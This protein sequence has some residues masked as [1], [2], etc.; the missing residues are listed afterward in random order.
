[1][2]KSNRI[3]L[4][5]Y[6]TCLLFNSFI[7]IYYIIP[8]E[9]ENEINENHSLPTPRI[10]QN[11]T[12]KWTFMVYL[13][14][15][16]NLETAAIDDIN[17]MEKEGSDSNVN[18][19]VQIDRIPNYDSSNG[20]WSGARRY[21]ITKDYLISTISSPVI[22]DIGEV[23]MG[24]GSTLQDFIVWT[25]S[26]YPA[27]NYALIL[28]DHGTG[29]MRGFFPGGVCVDDS[30]NHDYLTI[31]EIES[32]LST[33][34]VNLLG[35]DAC[36][37]G[38]TEIHYQ[39][40]DYVD[41][42]VAS[43]DI[44]PGDGYP[45]NDILKYLRLNPTCTPNQLGEQ[46]VVKYQN[47]YSNPYYSVTQAAVNAFT[48]QFTSNL[49][50]FIDDLYLALDSQYD[51]IKQAREIALE[52][53]YK[54]YID[55]YDF[56]KE[57]KNH[58]YGPIQDMANNLMGS[59]TEIVFKELH[60][61]SQAGASG[62]SIYFPSSL[63]KYSPNYENT[64]FAQDL[65]WDDFL[66]KY[67]TNSTSLEYDDQFE[68]NDEKSEAAIVTHGTY[69]NLMCN[70]TDADFF[71]ISSILGNKVEIAISFD[72]NEG[73]LD[74][75]LYNITGSLVNFSR[76]E[77]NNENVSY[78]STV[79]EPYTIAIY[80]S[81]PSYP[82]YQSYDLMIDDGSDDYF[83]DNDEWNT[84]WEINN[85]TLYT[86]L[87]C[88]DS[89]FYKLYINEGYFINITINFNYF[90]GDLELYLW[91]DLT[92]PEII[93]GSSTA[94][95][96]ENILKYSDYSGWY[97]IEVNN[98]EDN[99]DYSLSVNVSYID[100]ELEQ[101]EGYFNNRIN[102]ATTIGYGVFDNLTCINEDFYNI[103]L[104][105]D[106]WVNITIFFEN[107]HGDLDL[108][109]IYVDSWSP[110]DYKYVAFSTSYTDNEFIYYKVERGGNYYIYVDDYEIN[111]DYL[112]SVNETI[113][114]WDDE[115]EDNEWFDVASEI[116]IGMSYQNLS[117]I[118]WDAYS[119]NI[120]EGENISISLEF[121]FAE[122]D[123]DLYLI[124]YDLTTD[125]AHIIN[126]NNSYS[127][128]EL[129]IFQ[130]L[131]NATYYILVFPNEFNL[132]YNLTLSQANGFPPTNGN[133]S[134]ISFLEIPLLFLN[135]LIGIIAI[136]MLK[137][138]KILT[139][140]K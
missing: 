69:K 121:D 38:A 114:V 117:A 40:K 128:Q 105:A 85:N 97:V 94:T 21:Y 100:D 27:E 64:K 44:E 66:K 122:G 78:T 36:L 28:W 74:L 56:A 108:Y 115:F 89:D 34:P 57:L 18:I 111:L 130:S 82:L 116:E 49:T 26:N 25:K 61:A 93:D 83:E 8:S 106:I 119:F 131:H 99:L 110:F 65:F 90:K 48:P 77:N 29:I 112:L 54:S 11:P 58:C 31:N 118:D 62:L 101:Y 75:N 10:S 20:N 4:I 134:Y 60:S 37:M 81:G 136:C 135:I 138:K 32:V 6:I 127:N 113:I 102:R 123:L 1:M 71:N 3:F 42:I 107:D 73:N 43:E 24:A 125:E 68:E 70:G 72:S 109:L 129:I 23:N 16:C 59:I 104:V 39:L 55:L 53:N 139:Q 22:Q 137:K 45:Y 132:C 98:Y 86:G 133:E 79:D 7:I 52:F 87:I 41:I 126:V 35:F 2:K 103:S 47:Y 5:L 96:S 120:E 88:K 91:N 50:T 84:A 17:E 13:D 80:H 51:S 76:T 12:K 95:D 46:I 140:Y 63:T 30:S 9:Q 19:I 33:N 124:N 92:A 67:L 14:A 15:D